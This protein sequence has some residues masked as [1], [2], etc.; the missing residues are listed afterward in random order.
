MTARST[1][2]LQAG[3]TVVIPTR[4]GKE[5][6]AAQLPA[7]VA[8][9]PE[10]IVIVDNGSTDGTV[11]WLASAY[12]AIEVVSSPDPLSFAQAV[13]RGI[14]R[15]RFS[16]V[17]LLNNDMLIEPGFFRALQAPFAQIPNLF[18][19]TAQIRFPAGARREETGK[20]VMAL[21]DPEAFPVR[22]DVPLPGEDESYVLYGSGGCSLYDTGKLAALGNVDEIYSPA[23]VEDLDLGYRAWQCGWPSIYGGGAVVE[24]RNRATTSRYYTE[25]E[26]ERVLELNYLRFVARAVSDARVFRRLW[27]H[28]LR[29][30]SLRRGPLE[31][32]AAIARQGRHSGPVTYSEERFLALTDGSVCVFPGRAVS[33]RPRVLI[34]SPYLPF[35][36][37][38]GG[39]VRMYNLMRRAAVEFDLILVAFAEHVDTP[40]AEVLAILPRW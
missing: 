4:N 27:S 18:C 23:Y 7:I 30:L 9:R 12:P 15:A 33:G 22:C 10:Q 21:S 11:E 35:P 39:A 19:S 32:A 16:H 13:N 31:V 14:E 5:L 8:E 28:A 38:H 36:L 6:L 24:Q 25:A 1:S 20:T 34:A 17:C 29:R 40:P 26:L 3:V 2:V 37:S